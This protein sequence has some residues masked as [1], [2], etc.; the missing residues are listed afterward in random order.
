ML[1]AQCS[2]DRIKSFIPFVLQKIGE[3]IDEED[4]GNSFQVHISCR[5]DK[6]GNRLLGEEGEGLHFTEPGF[7]EEAERA[8]LEALERNVAAFEDEFICV[9]ISFLRNCT[10]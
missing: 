5:Q 9:K 3:R 2:I 10:I 1:F 6:G 4:E 7:E 8:L